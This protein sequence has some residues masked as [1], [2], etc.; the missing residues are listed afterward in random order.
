MCLG[1]R[2][3]FT[4]TLL[5]QSLEGETEVIA[6]EPPCVFVTR[7]VRGPRLT[8]RFLLEDCGGRTRVH[9]DVSGDV[10]GGFIAERLAEGFL[11][12]QLAASLER[13]RVIGES[14]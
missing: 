4:G 13:L 8:T 2:A 10:P 3:V 9:V 7:A 1:S 6:F 11:R 5:G 12:N 14:G